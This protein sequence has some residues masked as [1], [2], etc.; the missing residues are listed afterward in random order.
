MVPRPGAAAGEHAAAVQLHRHA[1]GREAR[2]AERRAVGT[3]RRR[4][5][6][7]A[8]SSSTSPARCPTPDEAR[9]FLADTATDKRAKLVDVAARPAGVRRPLGAALGRSACASIASR[10]DT[11]GA[12]LYYNWIRDSIAA[13]KPFDQF[14]RELVTA[15]GPPTRSGR[16]NFFKVVTK[17]GEIAGTLSQV[18]LGV[19]IACAECHHHPFDRWAQT[20]YYGM[21]AFF[22]PGSDH[23]RRARIRRSSPTPSAPRCPPRT[24]PAT[25]G[26]CSRTG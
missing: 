9:Q 6:S 15:E 24:R 23:A 5:R 22:A 3:V 11:S 16:S 26:S 19:R 25:A 13:N 4:R 12:H 20:D 2:E 8:A 7:C 10:S 18:F 17:P 21:T 1:R 14:A